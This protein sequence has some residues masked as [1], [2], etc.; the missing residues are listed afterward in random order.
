MK[1]SS[2]GSSLINARPKRRKN[3]NSS[4]TH[5]ISTPRFSSRTK[6]GNSYS[7]SLTVN[8]R[9][10]DPQYAAFKVNELLE[11][12]EAL[13]KAVERFLQNY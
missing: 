2:Y 11:S 6:Q 10:K 3:N 4:S 9:L 5:N 1:R 7:S 13:R 8:P 12:D